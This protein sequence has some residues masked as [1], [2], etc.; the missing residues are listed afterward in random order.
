[1]EGLLKL[2]TDNR[3]LYLVN[4]PENDWNKWIDALTNDS[5]IQALTPSDR[6]GFIIDSFFLAKAGLLSYLK[7][8][9]LSKYL[10]KETHL[11]PWSVAISM[12]EP[13]RRYL[14][15]SDQKQDLDLFLS[16]LA[17]QTYERLGWDD[18][19][20]TDVERRL[21]SN[22]LEFICS[23]NYEPCLQKAQEMYYK[24]RVNGQLEPNIL[25]PALRYAIRRINLTSDWNNLWQTY[26]DSTST[27]L[28][29]TYLNALSFTS[30][31]N[32][33]KQSVLFW[34]FV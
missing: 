30:N 33:I 26:L 6:T 18:S 31:T 15:S 17:E 28:K 22:I 8:L 27:V 14:S 4:Y 20:G 10:S 12:F 32:L 19:Q 16:G 24:W 5:V 7:P 13:I 34:V 1:M 21:R 11:Q 3:G 25:G 2:N 29:L 23:T 9:E